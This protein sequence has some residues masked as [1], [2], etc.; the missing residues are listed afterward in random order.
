[1][2][3]SGQA[4]A[5]DFYAGALT[6]ITRVMP[7]LAVAVLPFVLW[8]WPWKVAAGFGF[9]AAVSL[10]NFWSLT[11]AVQALARRITE[12]ES[13][14]SGGRI[15]VLQLLRYAVMGALA[16]VIFKSSVAALY[17]FLGGLCLPI[18]AIG[19]EAA[20]ELYV[21]LRRGL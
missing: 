14:E 17:G 3:S 2:E 4:A 1:M 9:G 16:Y 5:E 18:A 20:F 7:V 19:C 10:Y 15:V 6:R 8:R 21:A 13:R 11:R 12:A